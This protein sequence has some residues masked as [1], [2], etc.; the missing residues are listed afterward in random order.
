[1]KTTVEEL[2]ELY[3]SMG[4]TAQDVAGVSTIPDMLAALAEIAGTTIELPAVSSTDN[5]DV[6]T[7]VSGKWAKA[8]PPKELPT[9][10]TSGQVLTYN[11]SA[12]GAA[13]VP[14]EIKKLDLSVS[15]S[16][17]AETSPDAMTLADADEEDFAAFV[18]YLNGGGVGFFNLTTTAE[19]TNTR[20]LLVPVVA[21]DGSTYSGYTGAALYGVGFPHPS[22][23]LMIRVYLYAK[24]AP[25]EGK[26][27]LAIEIKAI[28]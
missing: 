10:A 20:K 8:D 6:L 28:S 5:G 3:A 4:G 14:Q 11:G 1:M 15:V 18:S 16:L 27:Q 13:N 9:S 25:H 12:W 7:V 17:D 21:T 2:K 22:T 23:W 19:G 24:Q 26:I